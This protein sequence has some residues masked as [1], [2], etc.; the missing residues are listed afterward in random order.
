M[1]YVVLARKFR[2]QTFASVLGQ[3]H[4][5][6]ALMNAIVRGRV[7]HALLFTG[8]RGVGKTSTARILARAL[9]CTGNARAR[10]EELASEES[11]AWKQVEPCGECDNC[12]EIARSGS[13]AVW[14]ID[15]ASNN[16]VENVRDLIESLRSLPP[17]GTRYKIY[18]IDEVHMLSTAAFNALLKSL[19]EPPPN[20]IFVFATTE[21]QKIPHTVIS[22]CQRHDFRSFPTAQIAEHLRFI[23]KEEGVS[24]SEEV[25]TLVARKAEG[26][27]RDAQ[28][29]FDRLIAFSAEAVDVSHARE[30]LGMVEG[31]FFFRLSRAVLAKDIEGALELVAQAFRLSLDVRGFFADFLT[32]W[33]NMLLVK[34]AGAA[35]GAD[36]RGEL[37]QALDVTEAELE[38]LRTQVREPSAFDLQRLFDQAHQT[39]S[40]ALS[41][42]YPRYVLEA[43]LVKMAALS[44]LRPLAE[45]L[46]RLDQLEAVA[47]AQ[48]A[49]KGASEGKVQNATVETAS[50]AGLAFNPSWQAFVSFVQSRRSDQVLAAHLRRVSPQSF[51]EG[52]LVLQGQEFDIKSLSDSALLQSLK[53]CLSAYS[54]VE[55][56][57]VK[58]LSIKESPAEGKTVKRSARERGR[59]GVAPM[60]GS[61]A[62]LEARLAEEKRSLLDEQARKHPAVQSA[63]STFEGSQIER[64]SILKA[65]SS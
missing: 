10:G 2:P 63:L 18:I 31:E 55:K 58:M 49:A 3:E 38:E 9:N 44:S 22:R 56:W 17:P 4:V 5:T 25:L 45:I 6:K 15:G 21:P 13:I 16:S 57:Q 19:E 20:T 41:S 54:A 26:S 64:V 51:V 33:R 60:D 32:H 48:G 47:G 52:E 35:L 30:L 46:G 65:S 8:P 34:V 27:M 43:G 59:E 39:V 1:S 14:E 36:A 24:V 53:S 11:L 61:I 50:A 12:R 29:T 23:A 37:V 40:L 28:S 7:P 42:N 62:E